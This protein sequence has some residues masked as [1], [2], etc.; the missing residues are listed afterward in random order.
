LK[1]IAQFVKSGQRRRDRQILDQIRAAE[2]RNDQETLAELLK[3]KQQLAMRSQKQ[4][5]A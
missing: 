2:N 1:L 5:S 3:K 4:K